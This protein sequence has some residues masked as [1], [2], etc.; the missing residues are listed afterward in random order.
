MDIEAMCQQLVCA[1]Y[2]AWLCLSCEARLHPFMILAAVIVII[3]AFIMYKTEVR[4]K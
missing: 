3:S 2:Q 4:G 1:G